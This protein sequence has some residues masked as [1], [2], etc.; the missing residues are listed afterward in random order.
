VT[1]LTTRQQ[2]IV[3]LLKQGMSNKEI[4]RELD[5][6]AG[7]VKVHLYEIFARLGVTSR[8]KLVSKLI[9]SKA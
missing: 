8:G 3:E 9:G 6:A 4:A 7:T 2:Q 5:I 1:N